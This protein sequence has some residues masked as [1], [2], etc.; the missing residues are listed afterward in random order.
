MLPYAPLYVCLVLCVNRTN[1]FVYYQAYIMYLN[2][3]LR[4][5]P[6]TQLGF[7]SNCDNV[8]VDE[9]NLSFNFSG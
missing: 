6:L 9:L 1:L 3:F 7:K 2:N 5:L 8:C 4:L